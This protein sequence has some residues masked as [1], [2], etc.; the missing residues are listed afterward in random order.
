MRVVLL[1]PELELPLV[2]VVEIIGAWVLEIMVEVIGRCVDIFD[3]GLPMEAWGNVLVVAATVSD[4]VKM[5]LA[6]LDVVVRWVRLLTV[7][8]GSI[9]KGEDEVRELALGVGTGILLDWSGVLLLESSWSGLEVEVDSDIR[10]SEWGNSLFGVIIIGMGTLRVVRVGTG[11]L[12]MILE[13]GVS[14]WE[15][16]SRGLKGL[17]SSRIGWHLCFLNWLFLVIQ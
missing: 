17:W 7:I 2:T 9:W 16:S 3:T 8:M 13:L 15:S 5:V 6:K 12:D 1:V 14:I 11:S 4:T 10:L